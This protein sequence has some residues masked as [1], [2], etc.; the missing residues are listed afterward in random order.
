MRPPL[1][2][3]LADH[4]GKGIHL[5]VV[6]PRLRRRSGALGEQDRRFLRTFRSEALVVLHAVTHLLS[7]ESA[8]RG[9]AA[10]RLL[11]VRASGNR[12]CVGSLRD[13][14]RKRTAGCTR[15]GYLSEPAALAVAGLRELLGD[16]SGAGHA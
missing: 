12:D 2:L 6:G 5:A 16:C 3:L 9:Q 7:P 8:P 11:A 14:W 10:A 13:A 15:G 4:L 1:T